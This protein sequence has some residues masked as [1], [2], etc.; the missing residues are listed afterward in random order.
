MDSSQYLAARNGGDESGLV[1]TNIDDNTQ[2]TASA[3]H[4]HWLGLLLLKLIL[5]HVIELKK[6]R[7][8]VMFSNRKL[9]QKKLSRK[10]LTGKTDKFYL[11]MQTVVSTENTK[12]LVFKWCY[13]YCYSWKQ[14]NI[15]NLACQRLL[16]NCWCCQYWS[17]LTKFDKLMF[18]YIYYLKSVHGIFSS[19]LLHIGCHT[20]LHFR[21][22]DCILK[23][24]LFF[25]ICLFVFPRNVWTTERY[26]E[27]FS[28]KLIFSKTALN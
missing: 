18:F 28:I 25:F 13:I 2:Q 10:N 15:K 9:W 19:Y 8:I 16:K 20:G 17:H 1:L 21:S 5:K 3:H 6:D 12:P 23:M 24:C 7:V 4:Y 26:F 14:G 11:L 22:V 27:Q